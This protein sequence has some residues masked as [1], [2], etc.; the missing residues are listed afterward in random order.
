MTGPTVQ[1]VP[2]TPRATSILA[3]AS[4]SAPRRPHGVKVGG[5]RKAQDGRTCP[6]CSKEDRVTGKRSL[7]HCGSGRIRA[8]SALVERL[9]RR[10]GAGPTEVQSLYR[11]LYAVQ[12]CTVHTCKDGMTHM[13]PNLRA[14]A[15]QS[16][17]T[18]RR[19]ERAYHG[20][21]VNG[22]RPS[23]WS[24]GGHVGAAYS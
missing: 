8:R 1:A 20:F 18:R 7:I 6:S 21:R 14:S 24:R 19:D 12:S 5:G 23:R 15:C 16:A 10:L 13:P 11:H 9:S 4:L 17:S 2:K 22:T 3:I